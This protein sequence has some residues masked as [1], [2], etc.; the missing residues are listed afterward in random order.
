VSFADAALG[1]V[2]LGYSARIQA[3]FRGA[4]VLVPVEREAVRAPN[5][6][7]KLEYFLGNATGSAHNVKR[8][9]DMRRQL[10]AVGLSDNAATR[11]YLTEHLKTVINDAS[12]IALTQADG[13]VVRESL[14]MG[15]NGRLKLES[16][17]EGDKLIT[18]TLFGA[19]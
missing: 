8:S 10:A 12:N 13:R 11:Q 17:W 5:I 18:G 6:G 1:V 4:Q 14:I 9:T 7:R 15:P 16:I 19:Q 3:S 2:T